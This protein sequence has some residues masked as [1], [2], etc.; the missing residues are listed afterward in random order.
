MK[1]FNLSVIAAGVLL[2]SACSTTATKVAEGNFEAANQKTK[3]VAERM[4]A[5][6]PQ[7]SKIKD[8]SNAVVLG[9][10]FK[11]HERVSLPSFFDAEFSFSQKEPLPVDEMVSRISSS[12]FKVIEMTPDAIDQITET[13]PMQQNMQ[14]DSATN[15]RQLL[16][17]N[18]EKKKIAIEGFR[19]KFKDLLN[20]VTAKS[21]LYWEWRDN[22]IVVFRNKQ[23][24]F[25]VDA[26]RRT[27]GS[28]SMVTTSSTSSGAQGGEGGASSQ[29][30]STMDSSSTGLWDFWGGLEKQIETLLTPKGKMKVNSSLGTVV[31]VDTPT[32]L[33][34]IEKFIQD[35][36]GLA[37]KMISMK[38]EIYQVQTSGSS[39]YGVDWN[40]VFNDGS[41]QSSLLTSSPTS[42]GVGQLA[43]TLIDP[44]SKF[45]NSKLLVKALESQGDVSKV[46]DFFVNVMNGE[47]MPLQDAVEVNYL[48]SSSTT[49]TQQTTTSELQAGTVISGLTFDVRPQITSDG[50]LLVY[51]AFSLAQLQSIDTIKSNAGDTQ[52]QLPKRQLKTLFNNS[53][54]SSGGTILVTGFKEMLTDRSRSGIGSQD[55]WMVGGNKLD[56]YGS[57]ELVILIT[58][59]IMQ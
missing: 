38:V 10:P 57:T 45:N 55:L 22:K 23:K 31:V 20:Y 4:T 13:A 51:S 7:P 5:I 32:T 59:Y 34:Q 43:S 47:I 9:K 28:S 12:S 48:K 27:L 6:A 58:P 44:G 17:S 8:V 21:G 30:N 49:V 11:T 53:K 40:L 56:S 19:G 2:M 25:V 35:T 16:A 39:D 46:N 3:A 24:T 26:Q 41:F 52:I 50:K 54:V 18:S 42:Q 15:V 29:L 37:G 14:A 33:N 1:L 36:N